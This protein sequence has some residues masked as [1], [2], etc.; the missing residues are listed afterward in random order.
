MGFPWWLRLERICLQ[1]RRPGFDPCI[2]KIPWRREWLLIPVFLPGEFHGQR[3][4]VGYK[5]SMGTQT[6]GHN[7]TTFTFYQIMF[8]RTR[9]LHLLSM[10]NKMFSALHSTSTQ[11]FSQCKF[12]SP[13][14]TKP[15]LWKPSSTSSLVSAEELKRQ[16]FTTFSYGKQGIS[17]WRIGRIGPR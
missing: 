12:L 16:P 11:A 1:C 17:M 4:L 2:R 8:K 7:W 6:V 10:W 13:G 9:H 3:S 5:Q 15:A 14:E